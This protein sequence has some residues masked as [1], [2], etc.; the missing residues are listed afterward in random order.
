MC[1]LDARRSPTVWSCPTTTAPLTSFFPFPAPPPQDY[2]ALWFFGTNTPQGAALAAPD[3]TLPPSVPPQHIEACLGF[4]CGQCKSRTYGMDAVLPYQLGG[5]PDPLAMSGLF[6]RRARQGG[7]QALS[8]APGQQSV[9]AKGVAFALA[10][11]L[12]LLL[13]VALLI[14]VCADR[15]LGRKPRPPPGGYLSGTQMG[16]KTG[17]LRP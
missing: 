6:H 15:V 7:S 10:K 11:R 17:L 3:P 12:V 9:S 13:V 8:G 14:L 2:L 16:E 4:G 5:K 1:L